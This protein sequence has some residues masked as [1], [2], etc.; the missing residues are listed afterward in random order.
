MKKAGRL[1]TFGDNWM[2]EQRRPT[3][4]TRAVASRLLP[5]GWQNWIQQL[6]A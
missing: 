6:R 4:L 1:K 2:A 5:G 3:R